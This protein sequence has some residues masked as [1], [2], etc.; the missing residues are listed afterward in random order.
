MFGGMF[1]KY[2][3]KLK[4]ILR[5]KLFVLLLISIN[6]PSFSQINIVNERGFEVRDTVLGIDTLI[7]KHNVKD[8]AIESLINYSN[9]TG[10]K[11]ARIYG[12]VTRVD[13]KNKPVKTVE[14]DTIKVVRRLDVDNKPVRAFRDMAVGNKSYILT[15]EEGM[16][17]Y[18]GDSIPNWQKYFIFER[19]KQ[20][21][22]VLYRQLQIPF[23]YMEV[24][25]IKENSSTTVLY[26]R[27]TEKQVRITSWLDGVKYKEFFP[28]YSKTYEI[29]FEY[30][31]GITGLNE[32]EYYPFKLE[33]ENEKGEIIIY[34]TLLKI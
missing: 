19:V 17:E 30:L 34:E 14:T 22:S 16:I 11:S 26:A 1:G 33:T 10:R 32:G 7:S 9:L 21:G 2:E 24:Y 8:N 29:G 4:R 6:V 31:F 18:V 27:I 28:G 3:G 12:Q 15:K 23:Q 13:I 20:F 5:G 25:F